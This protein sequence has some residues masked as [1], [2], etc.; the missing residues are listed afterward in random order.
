MPNEKDILK[1]VEF[2]SGFFL[3]LGIKEISAGR[4]RK[5]TVLSPA[6]HVLPKEL[7]QLKSP[8]EKALGSKVILK[9]HKKTHRCCLHIHGNHKETLRD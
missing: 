8:L 2:P 1:S 4:N 5:I 7:A 9:R 6:D 3:G